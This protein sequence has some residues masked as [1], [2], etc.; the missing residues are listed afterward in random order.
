MPKLPCWML[1]LLIGL[2]GTRAAAE[3]TAATATKTVKVIIDYCDG[4][5]KHFASIPWRE[6]MTVLE[7]LKSA[8]AHPRGIRVVQRGTGATAFVTQ[9]DDL[10]N[11]GN[12]R[13]WVYRVNGK[14]GD[15]G[16]GARQLVA[17]DSVLWKFEVYR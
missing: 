9:I 15:V 8:Q 16:C 2:A 6:G 4:V 11:E 1:F 17:G 10:A 14:L 12:G 7:A 5:E 3:P 13:N